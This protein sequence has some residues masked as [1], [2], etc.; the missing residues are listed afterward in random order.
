MPLR[1]LSEAEGKVVRWSDNKVYLYT[2]DSCS[3]DLRKINRL[4]KDADNTIRAEEI[5]EFCINQQLV[6]LPD[7]AF[8]TGEVLDQGDTYVRIVRGDSVLLIDLHGIVY[9]EHI[10]PQDQG[11]DP[12]L[13]LRK[14][15]T[16]YEIENN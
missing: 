2:I 4:H 1:A 14:L 11:K 3:E 10:S 9:G 8:I 15:V 13:F 16:G 6:I 5:R 12:F 7:D